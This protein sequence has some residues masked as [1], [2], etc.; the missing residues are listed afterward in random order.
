MILF[1][2]IIEPLSR[3]VGT[4]KSVAEDLLLPSMHFAYKAH[5]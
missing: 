3:R 1:K 5:N 2:Q 4:H